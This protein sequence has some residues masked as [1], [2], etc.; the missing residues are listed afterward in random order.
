MSDG[1]SQTDIENISNLKWFWDIT[2]NQEKYFYDVGWKKFLTPEWANRLWIETTSLQSL[3]VELS[4]AENVREVFKERMKEIV[5]R[6][7][8][9]T[10]TTI[11]AIADSWWYDDVLEK[12]K[13]IMWC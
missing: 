3:W 6:D 5:N 12:V 9:I 10:D 8:A 4:Q 1:F 7:K 11:D 13:T 2:R